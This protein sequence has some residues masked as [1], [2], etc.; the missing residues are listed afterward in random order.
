MFAVSES[1]GHSHHYFFLQSMQ[2]PGHSHHYLFLQSMQHENAHLC[3]RWLFEG[4]WTNHLS[5]L[6][7]T[8]LDIVYRGVLLPDYV[9][10]NIKTKIHWWVFLD[11]LNGS[12]LTNQSIMAWDK[13][14]DHEDVS[15]MYVVCL[16][17]QWTRILP[18]IENCHCNGGS[19][20][21]SEECPE[22]SVFL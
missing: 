10:R 15:T 7:F 21:K 13:D 12:L 18:C 19:R 11:G 22:T 8:L 4:Y 9:V 1:P 6:K 20:R 5:S 14:F 3:Q 16:I 2:S 17:S